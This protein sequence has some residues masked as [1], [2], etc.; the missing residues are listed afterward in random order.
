MSNAKWQLWRQGEVSHRLV[1]IRPLLASWNSKN[2]PAQIRLQAYL[3][4]TAANLG[5]LADERLFIHLEIDVEKPERLTRSYDLENYLT[6]LVHHLGASR[7]ALATARK[8]VGGGS[9]LTVGTVEPLARE[10]TLDYY[11]CAAVGSTQKKEWKERIRQQLAASGKPEMPVGP[12]HV[13]FAWRCSSKRNWVSLWKPT[14]DALGPILGCDPRNPYNPNDDRI[15]DIEFHRTADE[16]K[17]WDVDVGIWWRMA[18]D[19]V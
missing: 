12:L 13:R 10:D 4:E 19:G 17:G 15:V 14:G 16:S 18:S 1:G 8:K 5:A 7:F 9:E 11:G 2:D 6:P 3:A